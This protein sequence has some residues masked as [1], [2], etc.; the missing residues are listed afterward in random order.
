MTA[1]PKDPR[2]KDLFNKKDTVVKKEQSPKHPRPESDKGQK[3]ST[4]PRLRLPESALNSRRSIWRTAVNASESRTDRALSNATT[5]IRR[6]L[7]Q[8]P[9]LFT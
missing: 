8:L 1:D 7:Q 2:N 4:T 5:R 6:S 9:G 3:T